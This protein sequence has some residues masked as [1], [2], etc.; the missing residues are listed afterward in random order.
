MD[1]PI[2]D[3]FPAVETIR[4]RSHGKPMVSHLYWDQLTR[5]LLARRLNEHFG[6]ATASRPA[7]AAA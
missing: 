4:D 5:V 1:H 7:H 6:F 2:P 3:P